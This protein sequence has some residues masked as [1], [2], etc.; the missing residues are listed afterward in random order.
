MSVDTRRILD[1]AAAPHLANGRLVDGTM[2]GFACLRSGSSGGFVAT[3]HR[4]TGDLVVKLPR[5]RVAELVEAGVGAPFAPAGKVFSE[6][7]AV[8]ADHEGSWDALLSE[9][10]EFVDG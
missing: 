9:A 5:R 7:V 3:A 6:W 8:S 10:M 4:S 2:M 1:D